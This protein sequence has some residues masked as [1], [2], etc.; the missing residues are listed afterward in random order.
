MIPSPATNPT[1]IRP[2]TLSPSPPLAPV[3]VPLEPEIVEIL[4]A[5]RNDQNSPALVVLVEKFGQMQQQMLE[6]FHQT[7]MMLIQHMGEQH[8]EQVRTGA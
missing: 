4:S 3:D 8:R 5:H 7:M 2:R 6:Q 1:L